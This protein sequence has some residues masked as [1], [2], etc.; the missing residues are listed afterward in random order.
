MNH[1]TE[2]NFKIDHSLALMELEINQKYMVPYE[3]YRGKLEDWLILRNKNLN[4]AKK[5]AEKIGFP[6]ASPRYYILKPFTIL[7]MHI[8]HGTKCSI[9][10]IIGDQEPA[11]VTIKDKDY[12]YLSALLDTTINHG[13]TNG[14]KARKMLKLSLLDISYDEARDR[15]FRNGFIV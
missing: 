3:D 15:L 7:P 13:V 8:D 2:I 5:V 12:F 4:Y 10:F 1:L 9:N 14:N 6:E 11:P